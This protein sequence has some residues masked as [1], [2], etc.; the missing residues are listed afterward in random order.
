MKYPGRFTIYLVPFAV[1][2]ALPASLLADA[3]YD[4]LKKKVELLE[5]Q[6]RQVKQVLK[7]QEAKVKRVERKTTSKKV[8][9][10]KGKAK[11]FMTR[12][13]GR[14]LE[15]KVDAASEWKDPNTLIHM[16]GYADI[17]FVD[18]DRKNG[19]FVL[20]SFSP[21]FHFQYKDKV[22]LE[23]ELEVELEANGDTKVGL[24][25][26][27]IDW[28]FS[29]YAALVAGKF[30]SPI[31]QFRQ[32]LHPSWI[33][34]LPSAPPGFG[35]DGAAPVSE[36]GFQIRGGFPL[37]KIRSNYAVF[38][39][40]G[41]ELNTE[42]D[43]SGFELDGIDAEGKGTDSDNEKV[44]GA[45]FAVLPW[46]GVEIGVSAAT[47]KATVTK[48][49]DDLGTAPALSNEQA[50]D[51]DV[52]G[53]DFVWKIKSVA[54]RGE[55]V[56]SKVGRAVTGVSAS[57]GGVWETWYTQASYRFPGTRFEGVVRY[58]DFDAPGTGKDQKQWAIGLNYL[59]A[60]NIVAKIAYEM[61]DG[62]AGTVADD[63]RWFIQMA[64]GF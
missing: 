51:Y 60:S 28:F 15:K 47:G 41:P 35:H 52:Y 42:W 44:W 46:K 21:I 9:V 17:G 40:N 7:Q 26:L 53:A 48:V 3:K 6:L 62:Q 12:A 23:S 64:Y 39:G 49:E 8:I 37:G 54:L 10:Y 45:R 29:D 25:Y 32:N 50:R 63:N 14:K 13:E 36:T 57:D 20:G 43:G 33:N 58:T 5:K 11:D 18:G 55:Y 59:F 27:T 16:A 24:E 31:G 4:A 1:L 30:L 2:L 56:R 22:M 61:N 38:V 19:S 34:K